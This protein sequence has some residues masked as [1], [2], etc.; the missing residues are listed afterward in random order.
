MPKAY[1]GDLRERVVA[2]TGRGL[3]ARGAARLFEVSVSSAIR[4]TSRLR[5]TG[6]VA[7]KPCGGDTRSKLTIHATWLMELIGKQPDLTLSEIQQRLRAEKAVVVG[8]GTVWRFFASR[9]ISFKKMLHAAEQE[10][11]DVAQARK[12]WRENQPALDPSKLVFIDG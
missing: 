3:S 4:W 7:A 10:R 2:A 1:S 6:S 5:Q 8:Y 11:N 9:Q 12:A